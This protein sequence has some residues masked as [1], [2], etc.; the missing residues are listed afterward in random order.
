MTT[1]KDT[2]SASCVI[3]KRKSMFKL[4]G[5]GTSMCENGSC[6]CGNPCECDDDLYC[7]ICDYPLIFQ[8]GKYVCTYCGYESTIES[9]IAF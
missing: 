2:C 8:D 1:G 4:N 5:E 7:K 6:G 3:L 9:S